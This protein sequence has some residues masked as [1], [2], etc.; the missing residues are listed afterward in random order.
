MFKKAHSAGEWHRTIHFT[1]IRK[2]HTQNKL[3][4]YRVVYA[5]LGESPIWENIGYMLH[6]KT[7]CFL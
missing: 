7:W 6:T 4:I 1:G 5:F 3:I 2:T